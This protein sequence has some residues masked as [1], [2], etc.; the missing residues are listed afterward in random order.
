MRRFVVWVCLLA[1][2][3]CGEAAPPEPPSTQEA[4]LT[5][6]FKPASNTARALTG[7]VT[8]ERAGLR[9]EN[10][11]A[12]Y[13]R[14][15]TLHLSGDLIAKNGDSYAAAIVGPGDLEVELRRVVDWNVPDGVVGPCGAARPQYVALAFDERARRMT[16]LVFS[17]SEPPGPQALDSR[18]CARFGYAAHEGART[19]EGVVL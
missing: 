13:T 16:L 4:S 18:V 10:G 3:A 2:A 5:G 19:S 11:V 15:L 12:L 9:F 6:S 8:V 7:A 1:L 14:T 17:G